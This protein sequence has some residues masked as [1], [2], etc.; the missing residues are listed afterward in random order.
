MRLLARIRPYIVPSLVGLSVGAVF[1]VIWL[2]ALHRQPVPWWVL[3]VIGAAAFL[4]EPTVAAVRRRLGRRGR[5]RRAH[6]RR[7]PKPRKAA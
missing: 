1:A 3:A 2:H 4:T 6:A 7:H 5:P